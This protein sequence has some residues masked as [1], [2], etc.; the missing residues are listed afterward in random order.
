VSLAERRGLRLFTL[1]VMYVAQG[2]P[3]GFTA[4]TLPTILGEKKLDAAVVGGV[5]AMTTLPYTF[6]FAW[7]FVIDAFPSKRFGRR[8]P[9][10][11]FA[12]GMMAATIGVM[13]LIP[14]L[15][16]NISLLTWLVFVNTMFSSIQDVAVDALAVDL[17]DEKERGR[18][19]GMMYASKWGGGILGGT[20]LLHV[21][22]AFG[23]RTGLIVQTVALFAIMLVPLLVRERP[24]VDQAD[25]ATPVWHSIPAWWRRTFGDHPWRVLRASI[26]NRAVQSAVLGAVV[27]LISNLATASLSAFGTVLYTQHLGWTAEDYG[28]MIGGPGLAAGL[29]GSLAG[30]FIADFVGHRRL[31]AIATLLL[32]GFYLA[33]SLLESHW[34]S[35]Q[36][37]YSLF[38]IEPFLNGV[39]MATLFALCMDI[40]WTAIAASQFAIYMAL[41]NF[42]STIGFKFAAHMSH[43]FT[44]PGVYLAA[45][46]IQASLVLVLPF[47][48]PRAARRTAAA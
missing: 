7:G 18:A 27:M 40:S 34:G 25:R 21:I 35:K 38:W 41:A 47:I 14:D 3:W 30:G 17:L 20:G 8:R 9:W 16:D 4:I 11:I 1:C 29:V 10:I 26:R 48:D 46:V 28:S 19:N 13:I 42:S 5:M 6:K 45:A 33:W 2:I 24:G 37:V 43:W 12:Q 23:M 32:A 36:F 39:M 44:N 31:A 22:S 15:V